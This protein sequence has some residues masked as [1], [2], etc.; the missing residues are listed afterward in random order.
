MSSA[1]TSL[2]R[3]GSAVALLGF[4][5][6]ALLAISQPIWLVGSLVIW[7]Y[8][9]Y[10]LF[11]SLEENIR[12]GESALLASLGWPTLV[13]LVRG[14]LLAVVAG[15]LI[16]PVPL[17][18]RAYF[19][20]GAYTLAV[21]LDAV[22]GR[23]ARAM[24]RATRLGERLDMEVD[25]AGIL[26]ASLLAIQYGKLPAW[27]VVIGLARYLFVLGLVWRRR[28]GRVVLE[29][30]PNALR[31]I[32][33]G[34]QMGFL[35]VSLWPPLPSEASLFAAPFFAGASLAMFARDWWRVS[36]RLHRAA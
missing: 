25:A 14:V 3:Q 32:L 29:L 21:L 33:A 35:A 19:P 31:R 10:L 7:A 12:D 18:V 17:G 13:T 16:I 27:Y 8:C 26:I 9:L 34:V 11:Y 23:L 24:G 1:V 4:G 6:I 22:D 2:R 30:E 20:A 36:G 5:G 28:R 15:F